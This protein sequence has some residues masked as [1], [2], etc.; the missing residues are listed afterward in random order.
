M[1]HSGMARAVSITRRLR[2]AKAPFHYSLHLSISPSLCLF[3]SI[4]PFRY[5]ESS[6][7]FDLPSSVN[8]D[9][10]LTAAAFKT[11]PLKLDI[12]LLH[13]NSPAQ[14]QAPGH[15]EIVLLAPATRLGKH[16]VNDRLLYGRIYS[17]NGGNHI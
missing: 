11:L 16:Q 12:M 8:N 17:F 15:S 1:R 13:I 14:N 5:A 10:L 9:F 6:L 4:T 3:V 7:R 2:D